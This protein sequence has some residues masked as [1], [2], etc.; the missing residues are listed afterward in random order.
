MGNTFVRE[1][2][3]IDPPDRDASKE[4][5]TAWIEKD[6]K[7]AT[8]AKRAFTRTLEVCDIPETAQET[9][10]RKVNGVW[11]SATNIGFVGNEDSGHLEPVLEPTQELD[12]SQ[13]RFNPRH[14]D[15]KALSG[16]NVKNRNRRRARKARKAA[17]K[18]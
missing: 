17:K 11:K 13:A 14:G 9:S 3:Y 1:S 7:A 8:N 4:E 16:F 15:I 2:F 18:A 5:W 12:F 6:N 10:T